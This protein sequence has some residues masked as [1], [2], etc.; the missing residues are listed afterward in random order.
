MDESRLAE[1]R[2]RA[3]LATG[4]PWE[5]F[6]FSDKNANDEDFIR[7]GGLDDSKPDMYL[8]YWLGESR[9]PVPVDDLEFIAHARQDIPLLLEEIERLRTALRERE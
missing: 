3:R 7:V 4:A 6:V 2:E 1:I 5:A 8:I 9:I